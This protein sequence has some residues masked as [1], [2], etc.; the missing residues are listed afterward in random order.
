MTDV[1]DTDDQ[2]EATTSALE[3]LVG[4]GKKF[5]DPE[6]LAKGKLES[7]NFIEQLKREKQEAL[8]ALA[9]VQKEGDKGKTLA[10][11]VEAVKASQ[12][13]EDGDNQPMSEEDFQEKVR[14]IVKGDLEEATRESNRDV[15]NA[16]VLQK[17]GGNVEAAKLL[18]AERAK[19]LNTTPAK[20]R[21]LSEESP[22]LFAKA[23]ELDTSTAPKGAAQLPNV[24][25]PNLDPV[26]VEEVDGHKTKAYYD[27][28][29][30]EMGVVKYLDDHTLQNQLM[31][32]AIA[33][34]ERFNN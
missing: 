23:M 10:D 9:E 33:L 17:V 30:K 19:A 20:L 27:R 14:T 31:A 2:S 13:S 32:D 3:E 6:A 22:E 25:Q 24:N 21:E 11:L 1:F 34:G 18:V 26:I 12:N 4:E 15:G 5:A 28:M 29:K 8:D 7:D 16:L